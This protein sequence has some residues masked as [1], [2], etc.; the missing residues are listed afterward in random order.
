MTNL[1]QR[2]DELSMRK[3]AAALFLGALVLVPVLWTNNREIWAIVVLLFALT[4]ILQATCIDLLGGSYRRLNR[5]WSSK[6]AANNAQRK[7]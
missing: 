7:E 1:R 2:L 3:V 4:M 6:H 5:L